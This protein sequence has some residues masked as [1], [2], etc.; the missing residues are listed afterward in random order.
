MSGFKWLCHLLSLTIKGIPL[1]ALLS[2]PSRQVSGYL[3]PVLGSELIHLVDEGLVLFF[4][5]G[6]LDHGRVQ[7]LLPTMQALHVRPVVEEGGNPLPVL[8]LQCGFNQDRWVPRIYL[9][10]L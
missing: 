8:S 4:G 10:M 7:H 5:P 2:Y 1:S 6:P 9:P 3:A